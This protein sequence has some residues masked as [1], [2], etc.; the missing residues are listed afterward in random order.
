M[1]VNPPSPTLRWAVALALGLS[2]AACGKKEEAAAPAATAAATQHQAAA[3]AAAANAAAQQQAALAQ[4]SADE[5]RTRGRQALREQRIYTPAGDNAMEYYIALRKKTE[6]P[7]PSAESALMDLQ[8]Y[9]VI[10]AEQAIGRK[11]YIEAE[12]LRALIAAADPQA[13]SLT[14]IADAIAK[15]KAAAAQEEAAAATRSADELAA[16][17]AAKK[18]AEEDA[19]AA[20]LAN[21]AAAAAAVARPPPAPETATP[22]A[23]PPSTAASRPELPPPPTRTEPAAPAPA[24]ARPV[25]GGDLV[26]ISTPQPAYPPAAQRS[27]TKGQVVVSFTV[28]PDGSVGDVNIVSAKPRG[29]FERNVQ[30]A[31]RRWRYQPIAG[32]QQV[33]R[34]FDF[35]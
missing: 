7:D 31:V 1:S 30:S 16:A 17:E 15:G 21:Q 11:D 8:P 34:T 28:N 24:P 35:E 9:A 25:S 4:L 29:V 19:K 2:L 12:R 3:E 27:G 33:T 6:K 10:A 13:P 5:L 18:K 14:R 23:P 26:A 20:A 22:A 32:S